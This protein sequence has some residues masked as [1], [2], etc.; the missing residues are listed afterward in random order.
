LEG[1]LT[2]TQYSISLKAR[3]D[4]ALSEKILGRKIPPVK[5]RVSIFIKRPPGGP[6]P[7]HYAEKLREWAKKYALPNAPPMPDPQNYEE[8]SRWANSYQNR[9]S[10]VIKADPVKDPEAFRK[11][12]QEW[13][14]MNRESERPQL[15]DLDAEFRKQGLP[16][17]G[18][19]LLA[20]TVFDTEEKEKLLTATLEGTDP[21][22]LSGD[23]LVLAI[24][25]IDQ[26]EGYPCVST[27]SEGSVYIDI[28]ETLLT[29][30]KIDA[31]NRAY[32]ITGTLVT[33]GGAP[34]ANK[35]VLFLPV[36][37]SGNGLTTF[38][39]PTV[40]G[41]MYMT[42][43]RTNT[44]AQGR[45]TLRVAAS[46]FQQSADPSSGRVQL[47]EPMGSGRLR[48][49]GKGIAVKLTDKNATRIELGRVTVS[50]Q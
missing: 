20:S 19:I 42:N 2:G 1:D 13:R 29:E 35:E 21:E 50:L 26:I 48:H 46:F 45:F 4:V 38:G 37:A 10:Y 17:R 43:P 33:K 27:D 22:A 40:G 9:P 49:V 8:W 39:P 31:A 12:A 30:T 15:S 16:V 32:V 6:L 14:R 44:N 11:E 23:E 25:Q 24:D 41:A 34:V 47:V 36:D 3:S 7:P 28:P 18:E 5:I